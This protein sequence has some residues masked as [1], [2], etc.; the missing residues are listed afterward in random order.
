M[1]YGITLFW[2]IGS[3]R[4]RTDGTRVEKF[5]RIHYT[6]N[7]RQS[8]KDHDWIKVWTWALPRKNHLHVNVQWH[9]SVKNVE[10]K[11]S[12][13]RMLTELLNMLENSCEDI[14]HFQFLDRRRNGTEL[15]NATPTD[16][17]TKLLRIWWSILRKAEIQNSVHPA[18][19]NEENWKVKGKEWKPFTTTV[20]MKP[21]NWF[22][23]QLFPSLC[24][25]SM[26][27]QRICVEN[28]P[29]TQKVR[30][31]P[32]RLRIS[33]LWSYRQYFHQLIKFLRLMPK[34]KELLC[35]YE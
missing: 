31:D 7:S 29:E 34:Y 9:W 13:L 27:Q 26:E 6:G 28:W 33:N 1:V 17:G 35:E 32:E 18:L 3:D 24:S 10:T 20:L 15:T 16:N 5:V 21:L 11:K 4:R 22:Y 8:S 14:G 30:G 12:V 25:V 19:Q 23:G 2:S